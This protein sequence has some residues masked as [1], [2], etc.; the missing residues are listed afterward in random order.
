MYKHIKQRD[1]HKL[2]IIRGEARG[3][4]TSVPNK[5]REIKNSKI[6]HKGKIYD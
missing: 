2:A 1:F 5:K 3:G 6:K 4:T